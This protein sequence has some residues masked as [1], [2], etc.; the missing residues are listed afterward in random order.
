MTAVRSAMMINDVTD[1]TDVTEDTDVTEPEVPEFKTLRLSQG[2][3][4]Q[5][6]TEL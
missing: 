3:S 5:I 2:R 6:W 1:V 4:D